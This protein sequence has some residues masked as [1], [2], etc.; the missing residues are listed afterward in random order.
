LGQ[1][2]FRYIQQSA[3]PDTVQRN[4]EG[5]KTVA[6]SDIVQRDIDSGILE[7]LTNVRK[8]IITRKDLSYPARI[9]ALYLLE[10]G[11][12]TNQYEVDTSAR[13][14]AKKTGMSRATAGRAMD[15]LL[16]ARVV[17]F[18]RGENQNLRIDTPHA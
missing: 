6:V 12:A 15:D 13:E 14:I 16:E 7:I 11:L 1:Q 10:E 18:L 5:Y 3:V 9:V 17:L 4:I 2:P 8:Y